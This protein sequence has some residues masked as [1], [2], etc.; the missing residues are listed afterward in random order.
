LRR[1]RL[2]EVTV[3]AHARAGGNTQYRLGPFPDTNLASPKYKSKGA[4]TLLLLVWLAMLASNVDDMTSH[5]TSNIKTVANKL[6]YDYSLYT[7]RVN[8]R[9]LTRATEVVWT[10]ICEHK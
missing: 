5:E 2:L 4:S 1:A 9:I 10:E 6:K 8:L 3:V 7:L